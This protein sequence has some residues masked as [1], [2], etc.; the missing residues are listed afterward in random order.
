[1]IDS[2]LSILREASSASPSVLFIDKSFGRETRKASFVPDLVFSSGTAEGRRRA[3]LPTAI[4]LG[5]ISVLAGVTRLFNNRSSNPVFNSCF[6]PTP[7]ADEPN[8]VPVIQALRTD[9]ERLH[10]PL[11]FVSSGFTRKALILENVP[12]RYEIARIYLLF[13]SQDAW[14]ILDIAALHMS[15]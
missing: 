8:V 2:T 11:D 10:C 7:Q 3:L 5:F 15:C 12:G 4:F 13:S 14:G 6:T 9:A 1:M